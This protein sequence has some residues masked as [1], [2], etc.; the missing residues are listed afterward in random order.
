VQGGYE[1]DHTMAT[2][3]DIYAVVNRWRTNVKNKFRGIA[4]FAERAEL[5]FN[6][7]QAR[8]YRKRIPAD[9]WT[10]RQARYQAWRRYQWLDKRWKPVRVGETWGGDD[11]TAFFRQRLVVPRAFDGEKIGLHIF[12]G[13]DSLLTVNGEPYHGMDIF[14]SEVVLSRRARAGQVFRLEVESY[15]NFGGSSAKINDIVASDLVAIDDEIRDAYW[16]LW[17]VAKMLLIPDLDVRA[18]EFIEHNLWEAM[19]E[20]PLQESDPAAFKRAV[21]RARTRV[22]ETVYSADRF[23]AEGLMYLIGHSHLD[24]VFMWP[25]KEFIRKIGRT[26]ATMLRLQEQYPEFVFSQSQAKI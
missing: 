3:A 17:C 21:L 22:R 10:V 9:R 7:I 25:Y 13:G 4:S 19:K 1:G 16:D 18:R 2:E 23:R 15:M 5:R 8:I 11:V 26:H 20:V 24:L 12:L 6:A 14:R